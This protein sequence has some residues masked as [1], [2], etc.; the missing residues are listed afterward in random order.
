MTRIHFTWFSICSMVALVGCSS[1]HDVLSTRDAGPGSVSDDAGPG[2]TPDGGDAGD[3]CPVVP[4]EAVDCHAFITDVEGAYCCEQASVS[5]QCVDGVWRCPAGTFEQSECDSLSADGVGGC[6]FCQPMDA[7]SHPVAD[8]CTGTPIFLWAWDGRACRE[9]GTGCGFSECTGADCG[10]LYESMDA[11]VTARGAC[12]AGSCEAMEVRFEPFDPIPCDDTGRTTWYWNG[13][14]CQ[15]FVGCRAEDDQCG[16]ADCG[17]RYDTREACEAARA[18]CFEDCDATD[19]TIEPCEDD[20]PEATYVVW[21]G[22]TCVPGR[23]CRDL[24][25]CTGSECDEVFESLEACHARW[26]HCVGPVDTDG[27]TC[28]LTEAEVVDAALRLGACGVVS[29]NDVIGGY[30]ELGFAIPDR[31]ASPAFVPD[32][33]V[34]R[35]ADAASD[36]DELSACLDARRGDACE[37]GS[38]TRC[39]GSQVRECDLEGRQVPRGDCAAVSGTCAMET[40]GDGRPIAFCDTPG[41]PSELA[42]RIW[43]DGHDLIV[44][45]GGESV[46]LSCPEHLPGTTCRSIVYSGEIP[47]E[48]CGYPSPE[49]SEYLTSAVRCDGDRAILC[50]GG[51]ERRVDCVAAGYARCEDP[52]GCVD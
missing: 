13:W 34:V 43:C 42:Q 17:D 45:V 18:G 29:P 6:G 20:G 37:P 51:R 22:H 52:T 49:C 36:C 9:I 21:N 35:C 10:A 7:S 11:C 1:S 33:S 32:C 28:D 40:T 50:V 31:S 12:G 16:G 26:R 38:L 46:R 25:E 24:P 4:G 27:L 44:S 30:F 2:G 3:G 5:Q 19:A 8:P 48:V 15:R 39:D 47:G 41:N 23:S 14:A